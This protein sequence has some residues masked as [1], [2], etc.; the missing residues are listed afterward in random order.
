MSP[1]DWTLLKWSMMLCALFWTLVFQLGEVTQA[2]PGFVY[3]NF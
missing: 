2:L 3:V 1:E